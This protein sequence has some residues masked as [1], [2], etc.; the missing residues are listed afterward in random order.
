[1]L[2]M[3]DQRQRVRVEGPKVP[4][5]RSIIREGAAKAKTKTDPVFEGY[6]QLVG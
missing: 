1:M 6:F 3:P 5:N 2:E 4:E